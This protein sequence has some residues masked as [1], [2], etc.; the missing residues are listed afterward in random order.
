MRIVKTNETLLALIPNVV[1]T[2]E[3]ETPLIDKIEQWLLAAEDWVSLTFTGDAIFDGLDKI[4]SSD[5]WRHTAT[6]V[7]C[8]ALRNAIPS[9][10]VVLTPN[11]F[12]IVS[13]NNLAPASKERIERLILQMTVQRDNTINL[14]LADLYLREDWIDTEQY[15]WFSASLINHPKDCVSGAADRIREGKLWDTFLQLRE[16]AITIEDAIAE[17]WISPGVMTQ[18]REE[19]LGKPFS[20]VKE[21]A[22]KVRACVFNELRGNPRNHWDLDRITNFIRHNTSLFPSWASSAT[23]KLYDEPTVFRNK[24]ESSGYF[25]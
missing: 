6:L 17:K 25:F 1:T 2:V 11:G 4:P 23:A 24:K 15:A 12:G 16:R 13:N 9:L 20:T 7:V 10:D 5:I 19:L 14:L 18:L 8:E 21:V 3:G 22:I